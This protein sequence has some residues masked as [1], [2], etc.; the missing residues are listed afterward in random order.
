[1]LL[2]VGFFPDRPA[3]FR[4]MTCHGLGTNIQL[5]P[6]TETLSHHN[7]FIHQHQS[8]FPSWKQKQEVTWQAEENHIPWNAERVISFQTPCVTRGSSVKPDPATL[9][10]YEDQGSVLRTATTRK[11][12]KLKTLS[13]FI[14]N[15]FVLNKMWMLQHVQF[16]FN[17]SCKRVIE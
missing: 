5:F 1:M 11:V 6:L 17:S 4:C 15:E 12:Q 3:L 2:V 8:S 16:V 9:G 10:L 7:H 13:E 14:S